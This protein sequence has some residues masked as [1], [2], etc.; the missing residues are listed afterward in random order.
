M[1]RHIVAWN[2]KEGFSDAENQAH[3][4]KIKTGLENLPNLI[5]GIVALQ[6][7][8]HPLADSNRDMVLNSL[9]KNEEALAAYQN[10]PE[11]K[12]IS[13]FIRTVIQDRVCVDYEE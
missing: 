11:H 7:Y 12:K 3:A 9:F 5:E 1:V 2:F 8:I 10:H 4:L 6:V 13:A